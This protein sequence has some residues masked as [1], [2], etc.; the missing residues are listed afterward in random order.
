MQIVHPVIQKYLTTHT[1]AYRINFGYTRHQR[2]IPRNRH[3][4]RGQ[5]FLHLRAGR[6]FLHRVALAIYTV[7]V[8][9]FVAC[10][11]VICSIYNLSYA[12]ILLATI[13]A[14]I[15]EAFDDD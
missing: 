2:D 12:S 7:P 1:A 13:E 8:F 6:R 9:L 3:R 14:K 5:L 10:I 4:Q 15:K 11:I